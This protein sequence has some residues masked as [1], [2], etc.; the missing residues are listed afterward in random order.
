[1]EA[2]GSDDL[3]TMGRALTAM[4]ENLSELKRFTVNYK[5]ADAQEEVKF[6]KEIK[7]V[8]LCQYI[9]YKKKFQIILFDSF[10]DR[11]S[12]MDNY[13]KVLRKLQHFAYKNQ[14]FYEYC[15][16]GATYLDQQYFLRNNAQY[17]S[18]EKDEM[19]N[20]LKFWRMN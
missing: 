19:L 2:T 11:K 17:M 1:M 12:R 7:P 5:F 18:V 8:L 3:V 20:L 14:S 13:Y 4:R 10:R 6:F 15:M 16:S 9:Y